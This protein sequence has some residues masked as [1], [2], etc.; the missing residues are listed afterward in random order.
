M[1]CDDVMDYAD[2]QSMSDEQEEPITL[3]ATKGQ[4]GVTAVSCDA[5]IPFISCIK[6]NFCEANDT[7]YGGTVRIADRRLLGAKAHFSG[8]SAIGAESWWK[9]GQY[10]DA[11]AT[12]GGI[13]H[14]HGCKCDQ[15]G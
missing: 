10:A 15:L 4:E 12:S 9:G 14:R 2:V 13:C 7:Q 6:L 5:W 1:L 3:K 11:G 8:P